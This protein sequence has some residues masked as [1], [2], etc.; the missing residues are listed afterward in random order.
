M[1][2]KPETNSAGLLSDHVPD[3]FWQFLQHMGTW[4]FPITLLLAPVSMIASPVS[5][6]P[7]WHTWLARHVAS[8]VM[9]GSIGSA[10]GFLAVFRRFFRPYIPFYP[11][12]PMYPSYLSPLVYHLTS[13]RTFGGTKTGR[14]GHGQVQGCLSNSVSEHG[15]TRLHDM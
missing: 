13:V 8:L 2:S 3:G 14:L 10:Q 4:S 15:N 9:A 11:C 12:Y 5:C 1:I 6:R 7:F